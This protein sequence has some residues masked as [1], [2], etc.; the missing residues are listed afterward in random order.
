MTL[1]DIFKRVDLRLDDLTVCWLWKGDTTNGYGT[2]LPPERIRK[3]GKL[4]KEYAHRFFW[5]L[6]NNEAVPEG[7]VIRHKCD[8]PLCVNPEH[9]IPGTKRE[10]SQDMKLRRRSTWGERNP[11]AKLTEHQVLKIKE[12]L[13]CTNLSQQKIGDRFGV[14]RGAVKEIAEGKNWAYLFAVEQHETDGRRTK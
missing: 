5:S 4:V 10:N 8:T 3:N 1:Q 9:L 6:F 14:S 13:M 11:R 7:L 12:L 2:L